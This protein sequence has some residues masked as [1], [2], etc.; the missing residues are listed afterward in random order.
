MMYSLGFLFLP[1]FAHSKHTFAAMLASGD[2]ANGWHISS[3]LC[4][5]SL[6]STMQSFPYPS[7]LPII[8]NKYTSYLLSVPDLYQASENCTMAAKNFSYSLGSLFMVE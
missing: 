6:L 5:R 4:L 8:C 1:S 2:L 7:P 3:L